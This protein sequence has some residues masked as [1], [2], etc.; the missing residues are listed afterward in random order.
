MRKFLM[1]VPE[2]TAPAGLVGETMIGDGATY[3]T[4]M[5]VERHASRA[6]FDYP[7]IPA[8][9]GGYAGLLVLGGPMS[10]NDTAT[11]PFLGQTMALI[12]EFAAGSIAWRGWSPGSTRCR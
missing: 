4:V 11:Y 10:A 12:R 7:G 5:P 2:T 8:E 9:A 1:I 3:D 6:P